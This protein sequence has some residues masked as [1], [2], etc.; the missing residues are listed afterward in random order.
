MR[1]PQSGLRIENP[2]WP[3]IQAVI[4]YWGTT[5]AN[6][7]VLG[8]TVVDDALANE[9]SYQNHVIKLLSGDAAGQIRN[10]ALHPPGTNLVTVLDPFTDNAGVAVQVVATTRY[11]ILSIGGG[12]GAPAPVLA[13]SIGL[14]MFGE[15]DPGMAA[16]LNTLVLTNLAGFPDDIFNGEFWIQV[17][18]NDNAPG[19]APER[20]IRRID[21]VG[22][23]VGATGTFTTDDFSANVE[24]NDL[25]CVFHESIMGI[26]ILGFG[27]LDTS[28]ATVPADSARPGLYAWEVNNYF[29]GCLLMTT[30]GAAR[31]AP[32]RIV[33]YTNATGVFILDPNNPL[34]AASGAVDYIIIGDQTEFIPGV[35]GVNNRAPADV[36][37]GKADTAIAVADDVSSIIRYLKGLIAAVGG[38]SLA[39]KLNVQEVI[40][41]PVAEDAGVTEL[42]QD[43]S[44]PPWYPAAAHST[45]AN[46]EGAPGIAWTEDINFEQEGT[47]TIISIYA[48][49]EWQTRFLV[50]AGAGTQSSS[51]IQISRDGGAAWID[52]TDNF[53]NAVAVMTNRIRA[54]VG[55]W[56][57]TIVAGANQL[58]FRLVHWTD[59]VGAVSTSE[60]QVRSNSYVRITYRKA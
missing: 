36:I 8:T 12:G 41:Y 33:E 57:P 53:N 46:A 34:P 58:M 60:A 39:G 6:G 49:F 22:G 25:V 38:A 7:N 48:E 32:R 30:E 44:D 24:A 18:H 20:E 52:L 4:S 5:S 37:G 26:E 56:I 23:Y 21:A 3:L 15:C 19:V 54:G 43:G 14:W 29:R 40:I 2:A 16:S 50:G 17:I 35:D 11:V 42:A 51:K 55:L 59:D 28:S 13:P 31:F 47:I 27:T 10:I 1:V 45:A 9:P